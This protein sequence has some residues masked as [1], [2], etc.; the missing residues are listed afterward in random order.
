MDRTRILNFALLALTVCTL[1]CAVLHA[2]VINQTYSGS[3]PATISGTLPNQGTALEEMFTLTSTSD[4]TISTNS[5]ATGGFEPNL[6]LFDG[7]GNYLAS[8]MPSSPV[9]TADPTTGAALD[10]YL[11]ADNL[12]PGTY[13][14][15]LTDFL[16]NQSITATNLSDGFTQ[17]YGDGINF[18]DEDGNTRT[19]NYSMTID[20]ASMAQA[21]EPATYWMMGPILIA[22]AFI[23][24]RK[25]HA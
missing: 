12:M 2:S 11:T 15:A 19:G 22:F 18:I 24:R 17:N 20:V 25:I 9:A 8:Q 16:L 7:S 4:L 10:G 1:P 13:T 5:Y 6:T 23:F 3:F 14:V 21:P